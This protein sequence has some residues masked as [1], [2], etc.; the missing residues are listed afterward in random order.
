MK[1][2]NQRKSLDSFFKKEYNKLLNYVRKNI[3]ELYFN[4]PPEDIIQDVALNL[5]S[6]F[7]VDLQV[8]NLAAYIYRSLKNKI[9]DEKRKTKNDLSIEYFEQNKKLNEEV[10]SI[11]DE[12]NIEEGKPDIDKEK[13]YKA[14][15]LLNPDEQEIIL[16]TEFDKKTFVELSEELDIPIGTLLSR[17]HRALAKLFKILTKNENKQFKINENG[18]ERKFS[19]KRVLSQ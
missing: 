16:S 1:A 6:K 9:I 5:L 19:R 17:K 3:K 4:V 13:L 15:A 2:D 11:L 8:E 10:I 7:D 18:N 14:I 12:S